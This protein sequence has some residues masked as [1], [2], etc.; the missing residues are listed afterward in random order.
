MD[1][2]LEQP[3]ID[4]FMYPPIGDEDWRYA[5]ATADVRAL[6]TQMLT[7]AAII[8]LANADDFDSAVD[9]LSQTEYN[10]GPA[11]SFGE[12]E[13]L[14]VERRSQARYLFKQLVVDDEIVNL[15][16]TR[17]D[18]VNMRLALRRKLTESPLGVDY[19]NEGSVPAEQFEDI[20]EQED[21]SPFPLHMRQAI[22]SAVLAYYP[23]KDIRQIDYAL[24]RELAEYRIIKAHEINNIFL[25]SLFRIRVDLT[26]IRT[27]LR[28]KFAESD[29]RTV[30]LHGGYVD[31]ALL[32]HCLNTGYDAIGPLFLPTPY[33]DI[34][35]SGIHYLE[36]NQS[37]LKLEQRCDEYLTG[38]LRTTAQIT[39]GPQ[40]VIAYLLL[41]EH[42]IRTVR[43]IL[44]AKKNALDTRLIL[45]RISE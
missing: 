41:K 45:D 15:L 29:D 44:T 17:E 19:S 26:N 39:A 20:F 30:F 43:L 3:A 32:K 21:Y 6:E 24:D 38:F 2:I 37:F 9:L 14:L 7:R 23:N 18:F 27:M 40:P 35:E 13:S 5:F 31:H 22:E 33:H 42:E 28:L 34:V 25:L 4:F 10:L 12:V 8:D 16:S 36:S 11:P 1:E